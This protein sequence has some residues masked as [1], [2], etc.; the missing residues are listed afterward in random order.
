MEIG[1]LTAWRAAIV[2]SVG[3][4]ISGFEDRYGYPPRDN[5]VDDPDELNAA[6]LA[7]IRP[8]I[9]LDLLGLYAVVGAVNLPDVGNGLFV[10]GPGLVAD[11]YNAHELRRVTGR[12]HANVLVF[13]SDG[14]GTLYGLA[15]P[16]GSPVYRL[17][18]GSVVDGVYESNDPS[19]GIVAPTLADFL[20]RFL[21][22]V[23]RFAATAE[24]VDV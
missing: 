21:H 23:E 22:A 1:V 5:G 24:V 13:A 19:F 17:P 12:Y 8:A 2:R 11:A 7:A 9:P 20:S 6:R 10:H 15:S 16:T 3:S 14:G 18:A 4:V